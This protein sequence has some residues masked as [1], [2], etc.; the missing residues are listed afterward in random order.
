MTRALRRHRD[1]MNYLRTRAW[2]MAKE[3]TPTYTPSVKQ[4]KKRAV[5]KCCA[6]PMCTPSDDEHFKGHKRRIFTELIK[7]HGYE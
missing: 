7:L 3:A 4:I 6:C 5:H 2:M 1:R